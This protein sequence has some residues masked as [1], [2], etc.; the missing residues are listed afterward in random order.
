MCA[1]NAY[2]GSKTPLH[3][4]IERF[5]ESFH[6]DDFSRLPQKRRLYTTTPKSIKQHIEDLRASDPGMTEWEAWVDGGMEGAP[7][8]GK[9]ASKLELLEI[10]KAQGPLS[11]EDTRL[12]ESL[13]K[14]S[15]NGN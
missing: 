11:E 10:A 6:P 14:E 3:I 7:P 2:G 4:Q 8:G 9:P 5:Y 15:K 1:L 12:Y 13:K